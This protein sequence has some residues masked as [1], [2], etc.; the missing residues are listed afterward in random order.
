MMSLLGQ[1]LLMSQ[2]SKI[3]DGPTFDVQ[4]MVSS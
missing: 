4:K 3:K 1:Q 2:F